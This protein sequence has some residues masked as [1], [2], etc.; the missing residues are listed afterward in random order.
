M[1]SYHQSSELKRLS[2][3]LDQNSIFQPLDI[4]LILK[5]PMFTKFE[6][7]CLRV[8]GLKTNEYK[9]FNL[10]FETNIPHQTKE[11]HYVL[12]M[13]NVG[14]DVEK[15]EYLYTAGGGVN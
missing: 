6:S 4:F 14:E 1:K 12:Q 15:R 9:P 3:L 2:I 8:L 10:D 7:R 5:A 11:K 13:I